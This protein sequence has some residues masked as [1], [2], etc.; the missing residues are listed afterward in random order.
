MTSLPSYEHLPVDPS[1]PKGSSWGVWGDDD[2]FGCLNLL[3]PERVVAAA[4]GIRKGAVFAL[5]LEA[6]LP[7]PPLFGRARFEHIVTDSRSGHDDLLSNWNTQS[8]SQWDSFRHV[9][10][11]AHGHY[12]GVA[13]EAH[14]IH[15]WARRGLAGRGVLVDVARWRESV[16]RPLE[17]GAADPIDAADLV[18]T[19]EAQHTT[20]EPGDVLLVR[21]GW[22]AW[23]R[24]LRPSA[25]AE[26]AN[27]HA[28]C[29]L[30]PGEEMLRTLWD[31]HVAAVAS[32]N[33]SLE[34]WPPGALL[35]P[36]QVQELRNDPER[37]PEVFMHFALLP[38]L[39]IPIGELWNLDPL[40]DDCAAD[41]V[42]T[43]LL[44]SAPLNVEAG[45]AS[46]PNA[47]AI[48]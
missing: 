36:E 12:G 16:G 11:G 47:L 40:A 2:V 37:S 38:L 10:H 41:G 30:R 29:G 18:S 14:G 27:G 35:D 33:P 17:C 39:G 43:F 9:R 34:V 23:Y 25:R 22:T 6:E 26:M 1:K 24:A 31:W 3:T 45:V 21:T 44:T 42:Y 15:H 19:L 13:D 28:N 32:D 5:N 20:M 8:S 48:K 4:A 7:D 46:P